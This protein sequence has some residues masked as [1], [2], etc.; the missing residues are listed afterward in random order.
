[1]YIDSELKESK[2][3]NKPMN[4]AK[5]LRKEGSLDIYLFP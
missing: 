2:S 5:Y 1:M 3:K 4:K